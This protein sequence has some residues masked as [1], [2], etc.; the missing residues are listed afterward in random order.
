MDIRGILIQDDQMENQLKFT[1]KKEAFNKKIELPEDS[2][3]YQFY[4]EREKLL[5]VGKAKNLKNRVSTYLNKGAN[6]K[7]SLLRNQIRYLELIITKTESDA[8]ILEQSLIRKRKPPFNVQFR[9]DKSYPMI[10]ISSNKEFPE[11]YVSRKK[12]KEGVS[13]GPYAN[14][15]AMRKNIEIIQKVFQIRNCKDVNFRNRSRPCIEYQIGKCSAPCVG[16]IS[17]KEYKQ[18]VREAENF[19]NGKNKLILE[20]FYKKMDDYSNLQDYERARL[21]RDKINAIRDTQKNQSI[22]TLYEDVDVIAISSD[23]FSTCLSLVQIRDGWISATKN[24]FPE[25]KNLFTNE[26]LIEKF[27][28]SYYFESPEKEINLLTN[29]KISSEIVKNFKDI[30]KNINFIK[31]DNKNKFLLEIAKSQ[32]SDRLKRKDFFDWIRPSFENLKKRLDLES[33]DKIEA[34]DIS[35]ISGSNVTASCIVFSDKG[36]E[37]KE[38]RSMNIKMDKNDD[39][40]ALVEAITRR[41]ASLKKRSLPFP[42]L[43]LIDGGRGQLNKVRKELENKNIKTIK[44]ISVSKGENRKE[45]YDKLHIDFPKK[46]IEL[47]KMKDISRLIQFIRNES[48]RFALTKHK[49]RRTKTLISSDLDK[50]PS[51]GES[52]KKELIRH[53]GGMKRLKDAEIND[54]LKVDG[55]GTKK[56]IL[57]RKHL[58]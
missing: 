42:N 33:L 49:A 36:P 55:V 58:N 45:K 11:I 31:I 48:H 40:L 44:L 20:D 26:D 23:S 27:I 3:I 32:S 34:F 2:G 37:K 17:E 51:I 38:Y 30:D 15:N 8:L 6:K 53:F 47:E 56:A 19:L 41:I 5:Y 21:Y 22:L 16:L 50:I 43:I 54:L 1:N 4:D 29:F 7:A 52:L 13:F 10:H 9:D 28:A 46:E 18:N 39:Y 14:V 25:T 24:F 12:Q 35:H 57:I